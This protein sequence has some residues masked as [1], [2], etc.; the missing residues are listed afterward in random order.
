[1][2]TIL[3]LYSNST[4]LNRTLIIYILIQKYK[5]KPNKSYG[6]QLQNLSIYLMALLIL[7]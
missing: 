1:M 5:K 2:S 6:K 4:N 7:N 3:F